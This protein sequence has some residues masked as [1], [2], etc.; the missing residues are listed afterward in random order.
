MAG[1][2]AGRVPADPPGLKRKGSASVPQSP[3]SKR[4]A[5]S[6]SGML[7]SASAEQGMALVSVR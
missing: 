1:I 5:S 4:L 3:S 7:A 2:S 6:S